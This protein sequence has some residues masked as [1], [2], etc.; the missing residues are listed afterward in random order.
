MKSST[1]WQED[2]PDSPVHGYDKN[3]FESDEE[4][5]LNPNSPNFQPR[6]FTKSVLNLQ[7]RDPEKWKQ[8]TAGFAFK[9][10]NG[11]V[12]LQAFGKAKKLF[13]QGKPG[14]IDIL[15]NMDGVV[16]H[17]EMCCTRSSRKVDCINYA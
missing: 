11:N 16:N 17:G 3:P 2:S 13:V 9:D 12:L 14:K 7:A 8:R 1:S 6:A 15:R 10:L 5:I 4:S